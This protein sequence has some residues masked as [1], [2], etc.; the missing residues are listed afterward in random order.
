V[1]DYFNKNIDSYVSLRFES[2][3]SELLLFL[4]IG[5]D[6]INGKWWHKDREIDIV[7]LNEQKKE[8][9]FAECKWQDKV[10][11]EKVIKELAEK[12]KY[13]DWHN[14][15]R[16]ELFAVFAKSFSKRIREFEGKKVHC[17]DLKDIG[18]I[19]KSKS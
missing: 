4:D 10:D 17:F 11:A 5:K 12:S 13:V 8:I 18:K 1:L 7:A 19:I 16:K 2:F 3:V 6:S 14:E 9:L 15:S